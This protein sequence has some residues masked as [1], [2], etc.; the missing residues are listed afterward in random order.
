MAM[1]HA[2]RRFDSLMDAFAQEPFSGNRVE[3]GVSA[4]ERISGTRISFI[5]EDNAFQAGVATMR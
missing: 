4:A 5:L 2:L 3:I 1:T